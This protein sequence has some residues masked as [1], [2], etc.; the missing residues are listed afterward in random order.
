MTIIKWTLAILVASSL[1][2]A[3]AQPGDSGDETSVPI[4]GSN[5]LFMLGSIVGVT[6]IIIRDQRRKK[7]EE[8]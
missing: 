5:Y 3:I 4:A 7:K 6:I 2:Y 1:K 8:N